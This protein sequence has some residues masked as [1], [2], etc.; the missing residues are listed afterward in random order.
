MRYYE[1]INY[2]KSFDLQGSGQ[3][4][5]LGYLQTMTINT[6][7]GKLNI[8][9]VVLTQASKYIFF[10]TEQMSKFITHQ[11]DH[12]N[13]DIISLNALYGNKQHISSSFSRALV[14]DYFLSI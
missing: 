9:I 7:L 1:M 2:V 13:G 11:M 10:K 12:I 14:V 5:S 8:I 3:V 4:D 6:G